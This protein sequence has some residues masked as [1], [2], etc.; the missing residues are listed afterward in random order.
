MKTVPY[1]TS[2]C[3]VFLVAHIES[4]SLRGTYAVEYVAAVIAHEKVGLNARPFMIPAL[5]SS[6]RRGSGFPL[7]NRQDQW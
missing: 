3:P 4:E 2:P 6:S 7:L 5:A 1:Q